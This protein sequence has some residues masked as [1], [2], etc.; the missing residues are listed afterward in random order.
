MS[1]SL[2]AY[3][4]KEIAGAM[5]GSCKD[6][7]NKEIK[8]KY[9]FKLNKGITYRQTTTTPSML[10]DRLTKGYVICNLFS[11]KQFNSD[12]SFGRTEKCDDNFLGSYM[13]CVDIDK[14]SYPTAEDFIERLEYKPTLFHTTYSNLKEGKGARFRLVYIFDQNITN[15]R[16][17]YRYVAWKVAN[18]IEE[19]TNEIIDDKCFLRC[20]QYFNGTNILNPD[21][22]SFSYGCSDLIYSCSDFSCTPSD[23]KAFLENYCYL[24]TKRNITTLAINNELQRINEIYFTDL[25]KIEKEV[26][27]EIENSTPQQETENND[28]CS[29]ELIKEMETKDYSTFMHF[30]SYKYNYLYR[31]EK[32]EWICGFFQVIS[33]DYFE[34]FHNIETIKD[35]SKRR[36]KLFERMCLRRVM[37]PN[38]SANSLLFNAYVDRERY[39]DNSDNIITIELLAKNVERA[40]AMEISDIIETYS[41]NINYL[42]SQATM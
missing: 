15:N 17:E 30:N 5:I 4:N 10:L 7:S 2:D 23:Y 31:V 35:G 21:I 34:L 36:K 8:K 32:D 41:D 20:S 29:P 24:K 27:E 26:V 11:P 37:F 33:D 19:D 1:I 9:G 38:I 14:T 3:E 22:V 6:N 16:F 40:M 28:V 25:T 18:K 39:F 13:V 42:K 12:G